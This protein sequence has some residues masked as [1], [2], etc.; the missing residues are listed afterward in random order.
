M[1]II[2]ETRNNNRDTMGNKNRDAKGNNNRDA[3]GNNNRDAKHCVS[4][5]NI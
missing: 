3:K 5:N 4:T 1:G 2:V